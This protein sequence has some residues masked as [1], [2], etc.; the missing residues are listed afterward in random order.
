MAAKDG[1][2]PGDATIDLSKVE[3]GAGDGLAASL[4]DVDKMDFGDEVTEETP[5]T[6]KDPSK[7]APAKKTKVKEKEAVVEE[8]VEEEEEESPDA[9]DE[10]E[11][12]ETDPVVE[13]PPATKKPEV[14]MV[15]QARMMHVKAQRDNLETRLAEAN[16]QLESLKQSTGNAKNA[17]QYEE[18]IS[19]LYIE[20]EKKRA[21]G[22]VAESAAL[23]RQLDRIKDDANKRQAQMISQIEARN[24]LEQRVYD[25]VVAQLELADPRVNP[26][27]DEFD[28]DL[29]RDMDSMTRGYEAQ[30]TLPSEALKR[31][32]TRILGKDVLSDRKSLRE[33]QPEPKK[34]DLKKNLDAA[35]KIP[36]SST[37]E[38]RTEK[39]Q[40]L[41]P[42][43]MTRDEFAKLP[44]AT[45]RRLMGDELE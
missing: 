5:L 44:E 13:T 43:A 1:G 4:T 32:A 41:K 6:E 16:A 36:P 12:E 42:S 19:N 21:E 17:Q 27:S 11:E 34:T 40:S 22:N 33:K 23:A 45:Q 38:E 25:A 2:N 18:Q 29:V 31:A 3:K 26:D 28:Q 24:Q 35:K 7:K 20:L 15:P 30:G 8:P 10:E 9:E 39:A 14:K 37:S